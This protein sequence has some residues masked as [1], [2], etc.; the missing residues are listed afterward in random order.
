MA[1][2]KKIDSNK[3]TKVVKKRKVG[4]PKKRGRKKS[5]Y[6]PKK[7]SKKVA[8]KGFS[9]NLTYNR[10]RAVLWS[11]FKDD[12]PNYRAFISNRTDEEGNKI[13]GTSIVSQ[14]FAQ[15]KSLDCLDS[16]II[17]IYNQFKN[18]LPDEENRP[19]LPP[20]YFD[21]HYY[22]E[23]ETGDWWSGFDSR[24]WVVAP[25]LIQDPDDFLGILGS[26]RYVDKDGELLNRKFDGKKGD[27]I[28]YG[29]AVRFKEFINYCNSMQSQGILKGSSD[30]PNWRFV[31]E[32]DD[33]ADV[34]W[35]PFTKRWEVRIVI[36]DPFGTIEDYG[37]EPNEPDLELDE[38]LIK[39]IINKP[40]PQEATGE[41]SPTEEPKTGL[42][43]EE[44]KIREK[45]L[46][47]EDRRLKLEEERSERINKLLQK[48]LDDKIDTET[49]ERLLKLI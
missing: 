19:I 21:T 13:K 25:M 10:V 28:I 46:E 42:S 11:N 34:Y 24:V 18:Q 22:W 44:I 31:G 7:K 14:V 20:D 6:T 37:F 33:E 3:P 27:Y 48:Y 41:I 1:R 16:D 35:N 8:K 30:V 23:L 12:F 5:Y 39:D 17:E 29:K 38:G 15:C 2:K 45:E 26:D 49:F 36:C 43:K 9:R 47:Q 32:D 4:R 40:K